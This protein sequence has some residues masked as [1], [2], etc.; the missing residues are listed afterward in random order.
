VTL[1]ALEA[2]EFTTNDGDSGQFEVEDAV[3][4]KYT[5]QTTQYGRPRVYDGWGFGKAMSLAR[6]GTGN[7]FNVPVSADDEVIVGLAYKPRQIAGVDSGRQQ[8]LFYFWGAGALHVSV[9]VDRCSS[10]IFFRGGW[11]SANVLGM[12]PHCLRMDRWTYI[13][14]RVKIHN[15]TGELE[16]KLDGTQVLDL[17]NLDTRNGGTG[18]EVSVIT[19]DAQWSNTNKIQTYLLDDLYVL[20]TGSGVRTTFLGPGK[21]EVIYPDAEGTNIDFTPSSG[22]DNA[23]LVDENPTSITDYNESSTTGDYDLLTADNLSDITGNIKGMQLNIDAKISDATTYDMF[24]MIYTGATQYDGTTETISEQT[25]WQTEWD[26]WEEN[27]NAS[28]DWTT[29]TINGLEIGYEVA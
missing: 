15:T 25:D 9:Y 13:E 17:T 24:P 28:A 23:L 6:T 20:N 29:T 19:F 10:L 26:V 14:V 22:T 5:A 4:A 7:Y 21:I 18:D 11:N 12:V 16:V 1:V 8:R 27:P 3:L 2:F